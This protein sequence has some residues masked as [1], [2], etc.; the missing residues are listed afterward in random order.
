[1]GNVVPAKRTWQARRPLKFKARLHNIFF[2]DDLSKAFQVQGASQKLA[3]E[4]DFEQDRALLQSDGATNNIF[5]TD[6]SQYFSSL[7]LQVEMYHVLRRE[8]DQGVAMYSNPRGMRL[9][10]DDTQWHVGSRLNSTEALDGTEVSIEIK[11]LN[12]PT[13]WL[14]I[15]FRWTGDLQRTCSSSGPSDAF[16]TLLGGIGGAD[17]FNI[18]GWAA[19]LRTPVADSYG[20]ATPMITHIAIKTGTNY[21]L[22]KTPVEELMNDVCPFYRL[23]CY[24]ADFFFRHKV[25]GSRAPLVWACC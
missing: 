12:M 7:V 19:P 10:M 25:G 4:F 14:A 18:G 11:N 23:L 9:L 8:R 6:P 2:G 1:M 21:I 13:K 16:G 15:M 3:L 5:L 17:Y 20:P 24:I 22:R